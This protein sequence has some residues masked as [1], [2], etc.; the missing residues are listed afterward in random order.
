MEI[1]SK[2]NI[3]NINSKKMQVLQ[4][5][6]SVRRSVNKVLRRQFN[7]TAFR[8]P[9]P[10]KP[11]IVLAYS[12]GL[13]TSCQLSWLAKEKGFEVCAYIAD[14][15]QDDVLN[16]KD[17]EEICAK[18]EQSGAYAF[19][20][21][22]L[23][24]DFVE[25]YIFKSIKGNGLYENRYLLG[26]SVARPCIGKRQVEICWEEGAKHI[27]HGSTGKGND[28][29][30]FELCYLGMDHS[31][32][33]VTLWRDPEYLSKFEGRQ[34][35]I[36]YATTQNIP[37]SQTKKHSYSEDENMMHISYESGELED[38]AFPGH[39]NEYPGMVLKKKSVGVMEA[40]DEP[41]KLTL[42]FQAGVPVRVKNFDD[43][44]E[45]SE[46]VQMYVCNNV[47][48]DHVVCVFLSYIK[49]NTGTST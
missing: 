11:K 15:G 30:R 21:E 46:S 25:N 20:C 34:D 28:Q 18:A 17:V 32:D 27:S 44:T 14:L 22:D 12:G 16:P 10:S 26:T 2:R 36:D 35:L 3:Q 1:I 8:E 37:I 38:P 13:D 40:P 4:R 5:S 43:G 9:D 39:E 19:Y 42:D 33:C 47:S 49:L 7:K 48:C 23:R 24:K 6:S 29:V 41:A 45:I 31:L